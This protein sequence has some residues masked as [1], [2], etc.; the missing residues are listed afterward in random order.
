MNERRK[1][2]ISAVDSGFRDHTKADGPNDG[3]VRIVVIS[4]G[5]ETATTIFIA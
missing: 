3:M 2:R 1:D 4:D 5:V